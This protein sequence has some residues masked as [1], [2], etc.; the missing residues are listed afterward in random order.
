MHSTVE[1]GAT[2]LLF[3]GWETPPGSYGLGINTTSHLVGAFL[4]DPVST[5]RGKCYGRP[6]TLLFNGTR[7]AAST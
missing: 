1:D 3:I 7:L 2:F 5:A 4:S 6:P